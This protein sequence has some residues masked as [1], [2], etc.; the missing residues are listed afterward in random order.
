MP[1]TKHPLLEELEAAGVKALAEVGE[2]AVS[3]ILGLINKLVAA[4]KAEPDAPAHT[5][6]GPG[7]IPPTQGP[8]GPK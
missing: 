2:G 6:D 1:E 8:G 5:L 4:K 3:L 7:D